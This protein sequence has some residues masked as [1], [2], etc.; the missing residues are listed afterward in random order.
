MTEKE[1]VLGRLLDELR[2]ALM[3]DVLNKGIERRVITEVNQAYIKAK[4][5]IANIKEQK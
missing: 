4:N 3:L 2:D 5:H 1:K